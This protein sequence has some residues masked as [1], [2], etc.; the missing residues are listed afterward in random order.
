MHTVAQKV[1]FY[2]LIGEPHYITVIYAVRFVDILY[3]KTT[4]TT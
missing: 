2:C 3:E 1:S 4:E